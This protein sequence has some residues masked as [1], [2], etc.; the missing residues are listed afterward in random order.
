MLEG[1]GLDATDDVH[2]PLQIE[3]Q[4]PSDAVQLDAHAAG[5]PSGP[6]QPLQVPP[7][8]IMASL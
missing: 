2:V 7:S 8:A 3:W 4:L 1:D 5:S 6:I